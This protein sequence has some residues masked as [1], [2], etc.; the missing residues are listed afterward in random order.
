MLSILL[1]LA[2]QRACRC[3]EVCK[4]HTTGS[5]AA[6]AAAIAQVLLQWTTG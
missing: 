6:A 1:L 5:A 4:C 3:T 2:A